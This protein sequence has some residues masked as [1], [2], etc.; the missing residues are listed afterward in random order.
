[1]KSRL[2]TRIP[3]MTLAV[4]LTLLV[5][6]APVFGDDDNRGGKADSIEGVWTVADVI[7]SGCPTGNPVRTVADMNMFMHGGL[8]IEAPGTPAVGAPPLQRGSPGLGTWQ[9]LG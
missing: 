6:Q 2:I 7:L 1:M 5:G 9:H 4:L 8:L 3:G